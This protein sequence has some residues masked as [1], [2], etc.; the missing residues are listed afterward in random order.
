MEK[1]FKIA[2][3]AA[4]TAAFVLAVIYVANQFPPS[5]AVVQKALA[6]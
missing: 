5:R 6:G 3:N 1:A 2:Q 4:V